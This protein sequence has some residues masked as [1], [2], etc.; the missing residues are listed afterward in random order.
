MQTDPSS[1]AP[2]VSQIWT[3]P[4]K[5]CAGV[6]SD[7]AVLGPRGLM[8]DRHWMLVTPEGRTLTL[9]QLPHLI[10]V[11]PQFAEHHLKVTAPG[12]PA[13]ELPLEASGEMLQVKLWEW[14]AWVSAVVLEDASTWFSR[15]L[16]REV[17]LVAVAPDNA[18]AMLPSFGSRWLSFVD[19]NPLNILGAASLADLNRRLTQPVGV[20]RFR[21]NLVIHG[22]AAYAEDGWKQI[23]IGSISFE[24]YEACQRCM[25]V[26]IN[27][28][29]NSSREPLATLATYRRA[30]RHVLFGQN[31]C[32]MGE[33]MVRAGDVVE[34]VGWQDRFTS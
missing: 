6:P 20:E 27:V 26:N 13:L 31:L 33:G 3:Y 7:H 22:T 1:G 2:H 21:P 24:V 17:F 30:G 28:S 16:D 15:Y 14:E 18:R 4:I 10:H 23:K 11:K 32:H 34:T 9:R 25:V 5:S 12:M 8:Y 29:G 19:G